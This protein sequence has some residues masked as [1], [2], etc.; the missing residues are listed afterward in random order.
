MT[1]IEKW[2]YFLKDLES[3]DLFIDW[4]FYSM[5]STALQRRVWLFPDTFT[6]YPNLFVLLVGPP[7]AGKSRVISQ[8]SEHIKNPV[9]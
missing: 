7:A 3:P 8:V 1:N 4:G 5:I 2:R 6:L 9:L